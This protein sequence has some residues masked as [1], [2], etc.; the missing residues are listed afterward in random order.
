[1]DG[2]VCPDTHKHDKTTYCR[3]HHKCSCAPCRANQ[4]KYQRMLRRMQ[5]VDVLVLTGPSTRQLQALAVLGWSTKEIADMAGTTARQQY[6]IIRSG[7][8]HEMHKSMAERI[9]RVYDKLHNTPNPKK[10]GPKQVIAQARKAGWHHPLDWEDIDAGI[11]YDDGDDSEEYF[12]HVAVGLVLD[13]TPVDQKFTT[14]ELEAIVRT[15][16]LERR[17]TDKQI[18]ELVHKPTPVV[19]QVRKSLNIPRI[20]KDELSALRIDK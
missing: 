14:A 4:A 13:G 5:G 11:L 9:R 10:N 19:T 8:Q 7:A 1:M 15:L 20:P 6:S 3:T 2:Y 16:N 12:D 17:Y 18:S